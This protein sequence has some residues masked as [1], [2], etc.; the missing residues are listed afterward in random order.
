MLRCALFE[1]TLSTRFLPGDHASSFVL[2]NKCSTQVS[3][4]SL[5]KTKMVTNK[6]HTVYEE[7]D[8]EQNSETRH[9]T[10][11]FLFDVIRQ[12][13]KWKTFVCIPLSK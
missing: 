6:K 10:Q 12:I 8:T 3:I 11:N 4:H 9:H 1:L 7:R 5:H 2:F 13:N